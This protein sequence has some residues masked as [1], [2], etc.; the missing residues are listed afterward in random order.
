MKDSGQLNGRTFALMDGSVSSPP[1]LATGFQ[2]GD[3]W[4]IHSLR[5]Q[6]DSGALPHGLFTPAACIQAVPLPVL[7]HLEETKSGQHG[8][9][10]QISVLLER[11]HACDWQI[12]WTNFPL[13]C[14]CATHRWELYISSLLH[15]RGL[16]A[17]PS[18]DT[19][20]RPPSGL[21]LQHAH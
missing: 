12:S 20:L 15:S 21:Y 16:R 4:T 19:Y 8:N 18:C 11:E 5:S 10:E 6:Q 13:I 17:A 7:F 1:S 3:P 2:M 14:L 9:S